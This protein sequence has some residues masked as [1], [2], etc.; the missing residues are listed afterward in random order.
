[1]LTNIPRPHLE[2]SAT[3]MRRASRLSISGNPV[4][5]LVATRNLPSNTSEDDILDEPFDSLEPPL[6][7]T[8]VRLSFGMFGISALMPWN[9][10]HSYLA[11]WPS[12]PY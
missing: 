5:P 3:V 8:G 11:Y 12:V 2:P 7:E 4:S 1:M 9:G 10:M 6:V